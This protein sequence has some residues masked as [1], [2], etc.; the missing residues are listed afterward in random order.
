[1]ILY[2]NL[3]L[4][5]P[6]SML[7]GIGTTEGMGLLWHQ[8]TSVMR[9]GDLVLNEFS[10]WTILSKELFLVGTG[11]SKTWAEDWWIGDWCRV[12]TTWT[13][14]EMGELKMTNH[15]YLVLWQCRRL[16]W[17][18]IWTDWWGQG[19]GGDIWQAEDC[20]Q[21]VLVTGDLQLSKH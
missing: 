14:L 16:G 17:P 2:T 8:Q 6:R 7:W 3:Y 20:G 11:Q 5:C 12:P 15:W 21:D 1:M 4:P 9:W 18:C 13:G 19:G 10:C